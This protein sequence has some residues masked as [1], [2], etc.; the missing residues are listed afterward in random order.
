MPGGEETVREEVQDESAD[1]KAQ[2]RGV[3]ARPGI[4]LLPYPC[5]WTC[6]EKAETAVKEM[7][8]CR[9]GRMNKRNDKKGSDRRQQNTRSIARTLHH[10]SK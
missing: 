9:N 2:A 3:C 10:H 4:E 1:G 5:G 8:E 6:L 7:R